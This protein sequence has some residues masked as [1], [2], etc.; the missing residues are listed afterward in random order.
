MS[1]LSPFRLS[2]WQGSTFACVCLLGICSSPSLLLPL[3]AN[4]SSQP[5]T[6]AMVIDRVIAVVNTQAI[7][8]SDLQDE[9]QLAVLD[10][11]QVGSN[12]H[13]A[14][15][16]LDRLISRTLIEQQ[17]RQEDAS[18]LDPTQDEINA[19]IEQMRTQLP[20]C[21]RQ[22][23][24]SDDGWK[25][26]LAAHNLTSARVNTYLS[27][28]LRILRFIEIR[29]QQGISISQQDIAAYYK[30]KLLPQ[31]APS[32]T[33]PPLDQVSSRIQE[34]LLQQQVNLLFDDW[35]QS[36]RQQGEVEILDHSLELPQ[37]AE[38]KSNGKEGG[39]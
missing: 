19:R 5:G 34:I 25:A 4:D 11:N 13:S 8:A 36:L 22:H 35:L 28:R 21:V 24:A 2:R 10:P 14:A 37:S 7:L 29:F 18:A 26:F 38:T 15:Q 33:V 27:H 17:I 23:C 31:Y 20:A 1:R 3:Q 30:D 16:V 6:E 12:N 9:M 39:E 32:E